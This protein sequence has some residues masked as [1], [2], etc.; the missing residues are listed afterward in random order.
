[1]RSIATIEDKGGNMVYPVR[2]DEEIPGKARIVEIDPRRVVFV[3]TQANRREFVELPEE[4]INPKVSVGGT[5]VATPGIEQVA[6]NQ[7]NIDRKE[8]DK[9]LG[10]INN[11]LTQARAVPN[12][13]NGVAAGYKL[14]QIVPGSI[15]DKLGLKNGDVIAGFDG[16]PI[17]DPSQ[18]FTALNGLRQRSNLDLQ[19][20]RD[21]RTQTFSYD[22]H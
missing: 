10:D 12:F 3:N 2:I 4:G 22:I 13:E 16:Q 14:F 8:V 15:Y 19:I 20:K 17:T 5:T 1:M 9:A 11:I 7:F 21:G 6:T 18:A